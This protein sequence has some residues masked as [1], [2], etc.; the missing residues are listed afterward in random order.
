MYYIISKIE[1]ADG[2]LKYTPDSYTLDESINDVVV[3][4]YQETLGSWLFTN[5][6]ALTNGTVLLSEKF[7]QNEIYYTVN[8]QTTEFETSILSEI[9]NVNQLSW[10]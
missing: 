10:L 3:N 1:L 8:I 2:M 9:T 4:N 7:S 5:A 6:E